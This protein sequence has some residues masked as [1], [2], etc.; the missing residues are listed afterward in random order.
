MNIF[1]ETDSFIMRSI[2]EEDVN[3]ILELY[4][5]VQVHKY[6]CEEPI[7]DIEQA[8]Q[9]LN[10]IQAQYEQYGIGRW[11]VVDSKSGEFMGWSGLKFETDVREEMNY[12]DLGYRFK[13][14]FW[15]QGLA[16][17]TSIVSLNYGF[18]QLEL[19]Q[20]Y[21]GAHLKNTASNRVLRKCGF[22]W[23]ELFNYEGE[24]HNWYLLKKKSFLSS[25]I[26][27]L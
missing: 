1:Y 18:K 23:L 24:P 7:S 17:A 26:G 4:S 6:L 11:A 8:H 19:E 21:A 12:Y 13:S 5:D 25:S 22:R 9:I 10:Y 16:T 14:K 20:I 3:G 27:N 15:G 2:M